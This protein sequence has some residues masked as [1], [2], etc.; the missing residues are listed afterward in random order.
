MAVPVA[1]P[2]TAAA[3]CRAGETPP[4]VTAQS[5]V[6]VWVDQIGYRAAARKI[7]IVAADGPLPGDLALEVGDAKTH[8]SVWRLKDHPD[9]LKPGGGTGL[10]R[11]RLE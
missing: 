2:A 4:P 10:R 6:R 3:W 1:V 11:H 7:V 9:A 5:A 8:E